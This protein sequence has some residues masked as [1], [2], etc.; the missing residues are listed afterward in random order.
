MS[1]PTGNSACC[2]G[3]EANIG[4]DGTLDLTIE[5]AAT[6]EVGARGAA[7]APSQERRTDIA[8]AYRPRTSTRTTLAHHVAASP[9]HG[10]PS[11][12]IGTRISRPRSARARIEI[13]GD[14]AHEDVD[15]AL[16]RRALAA[17]CL[18]ALDS[19]A[20]RSLN[21]PM[22]TPFWRTRC[23][24]ASLLTLRQLLAVGLRPAPAVGID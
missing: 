1:N 9:A 4:V 22:S 21:S 17:G 10:M 6:F 8:A 15:H 3:V 14:P 19:D 24:R 23:W 12:P 5:E 2:K 18:F 7:L 16:A 13:D 11:S 20:I